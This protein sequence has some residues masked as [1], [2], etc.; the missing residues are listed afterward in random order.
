MTGKVSENLI[1]TDCWRVGFPATLTATVRADSG[2]YSGGVVY[3]PAADSPSGGCWRGSVDVAF[4][5]THGESAARRSLSLM[6]SCKT[7]P[8]I[9][10]PVISLKIG[11][12]ELGLAAIPRVWIYPDPERNIPLCLTYHVP[13]EPGVGNTETLIVVV[14][15]SDLEAQDPQQCVVQTDCQCAGAGY[16]PRHRCEKTPEWHRLCWT[17]ADYFQLWEHGSGPGQYS[18]EPI[19]PPTPSEPGLIRKA[20]NLAAATAAFIA[21]GMQTVDE[22][23]F[24]RRLAICDTCDQRQENRCRACGCNLDLKARGR[25]MQCP[26][27]KWG[28]V[29]AATGPPDSNRSFGPPRSQIGHVSLATKRQRRQ[30]LRETHVAVSD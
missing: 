25:V 3:H 19:A 8:W 13:P 22:V 26:L 24:A 9:P 18:D 15:E 28:P 21:D 29:P 12:E 16:C 5:Q 30:Q 23:E 14:T 17:R 11:S 7:L 20:W 1:M 2:L 27:S 6:L 10:S 4:G